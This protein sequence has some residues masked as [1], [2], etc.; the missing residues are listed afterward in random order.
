[1]ARAVLRRVFKILVVEGAKEG[2]R[3]AKKKDNQ[4]VNLGIDVLGNIWTAMERAD[5]RCWAML[6]AYL[7]ALRVEI[8]EGEHTL[9]LH[10]GLHGRKVGP[11][12]SVRI[13][14]R[15]GFNT[16]VI[17]LVPTLHGGPPPLTSESL[18]DL[19]PQE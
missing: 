18:E 1:V 16:Y 9:T 8:P 4:W 14:V 12:Q 11:P 10:A 19:E 3:K 2:V 7:Q 5:T 17:G 15:N 13:Q 6:P